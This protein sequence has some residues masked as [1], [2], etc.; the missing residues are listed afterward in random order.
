MFGK[1]IESIKVLEVRDSSGKNV[2]WDSEAGDSAYLLFGVPD[3]LA[4]L[5][6]LAVN[7]VSGVTI[8]PRLRN[9]SYSKN[10]GETL[11]SSE[12]LRAFI[13]SKAQIYGEENE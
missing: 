5:L 10:P 2:F 7:S 4:N 13:E 6:D 3:E 8:K 11:V 1:L 12:E 9:A